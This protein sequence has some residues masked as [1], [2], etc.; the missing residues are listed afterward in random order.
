MKRVTVSLSVSEKK[1]RLREEAWNILEDRDVARFPRPVRGRIPNFR[2]SEEAARKLLDTDEFH[3]AEVVKVN[4]D[5][6]Q[7]EV[8]RGVLKAGKILIMPSPR[9]RAGFLILD[10]AGIP[11]RLYRR[12]ATIRGSFRHAKRTNLRDLPIV[13]LIVCGSVAVTEGGIRVG[14]GGGYSDLEYAILRELGLVDEETP[15]ATTVHDLQVFEDAPIEK[16]DF[17]NR[18]HRHTHE[19]NKN[20]WPTPQTQGHNLGKA[21]RRKTE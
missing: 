14:K 2:G 12:A 21:L 7:L 17:S 6:P 11:D 3:L 18:P 15:I 16:Q 5:S 1:R 8:R 4:Q 13:E 10:P 20:N 9:L 19:A